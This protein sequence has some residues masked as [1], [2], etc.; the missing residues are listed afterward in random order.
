MQKDLNVVIVEDDPYA[1][2]FMSL[3]LRRDWRTRVV[4]EFGSH[5]TIE[6]QNV[7]R[8]QLARIDVLIVDT[9]VPDHESWP[10]KVAQIIRL[11][12]AAH[13][14]AVLY[15]CTT[16]NLR[17]LAHI[18]DVKGSGYI[19]KNEIRYA[20][21]SAVSAA[22]SGSFVLTPSAYMLAGELDLPDVSV[23][24]DGA[25]PAADFTPREKELMRLG[26]LFNLAQR[27]IAD[28]LIVSTDF[29]A[30]VI[31]QVYKKLGV[32]EI[33]AGEKELEAYF[34]DEK[35]LVRCREILEQVSGAGRKAP[36]M[37]TLAFHLLTIPASTE[38]R[39]GKE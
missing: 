29:V 4:G 24:L 19:V 21:A 30:E 37:S 16:P 8:Q 36:W 35:L 2:D 11:L 26:L 10:V 15:T 32:R 27:D 23:I 38:I 20:L 22:A 34:N 33:I 6:L 1:R 28:D 39:L 5:S 9:E 18:L 3:L 31:G 7:L 17:V 13:T 25:L 14:P 12:P